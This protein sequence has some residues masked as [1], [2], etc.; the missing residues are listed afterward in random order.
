MSEK[1]TNDNGWTMTNNRSSPSS[2]TSLF[3]FTVAGGA[4]K[5]HFWT[6][7]YCCETVTRS[8]LKRCVCHCETSRAPSH[9]RLAAYRPVHV[10]RS[11]SPNHRWSFPLILSHSRR[12]TTN[13]KPPVCLSQGG[14]WSL[15]PPP[16][17]LSLCVLSVK[18][19][20]HRLTHSPL[21]LQPMNVLRMT[22]V[23]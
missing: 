5:K 4:K 9:P 12:H 19:L 14:K 21:Y 11:H 16:P 15:V 7:D 6:I 1:S 23:S 22:S 10:P 3:C 18:R 17:P 8:R 13:V 2:L 20:F